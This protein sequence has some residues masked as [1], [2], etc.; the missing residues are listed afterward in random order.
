MKF[1]INIHQLFTEGPCLRRRKGEP[2]GQILSQ[3]DPPDPFHHIKGTAD[4]GFI[5]CIG[6]WLRTIGKEGFQG[7][8]N[9]VFPPHVMGRF[10]FPAKGRTTEDHFPVAHFQ[11]VGQIGMAAGELSHGQFS[12]KS[13]DGV[14][15]E[16]FHLHQIK[17]FTFP[18][19]LGLINIFHGLISSLRALY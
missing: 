1:H 9:P 11:Q 16:G 2:F 5:L 8:L 10:R 6:Q 15:Q 18:D 4:D 19:R 3:N 17:F 7:F 12:L 14:L 13:R